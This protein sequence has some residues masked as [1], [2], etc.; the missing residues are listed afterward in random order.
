[1]RTISKIAMACSL[2]LM[3]GCVMVPKTFEADIRIEI[4][5]VQKQ[6]DDVLD[7]IEGK[8]GDDT[9][10]ATSSSRVFD[11]AAPLVLYAA[12]HQQQPQIVPGIAGHAYYY[13]VDGEQRSLLYF[14]INQRPFH[15]SMIADQPAIYLDGHPTAES[16][17]IVLASQLDDDSPRVRQIADS[18]KARYNDVQALKK[19]GYIG[20]N[21]RGLIEIPPGARIDD[22][23]E[24]NQV[25]RMIA[26]ENQDRKALYAEV[27]RLNK[28]QNLN[29]GT[30]ERVYAQ[31]RLER[32]NS[33][34]YFQLPAE[35]PDF[36]AIKN[37]ALGKKLGP[38]CIPG[39]WIRVR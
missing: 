8:T 36:D 37:A 6:A 33:G 34:E 14:P 19:K 29:V 35:G 26:A 25:Q 4:T 9:P 31:K 22:P 11:P 30:V 2:A 23:E 1:M 32:A 27:A 7:Y 21:N 16:G 38:D 20:E 10:G 3:A 18:M 5:H 15:P 28:E 12:D 24:K 17:R 39:A 13:A